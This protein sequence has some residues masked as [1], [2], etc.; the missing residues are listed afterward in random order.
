MNTY[1]IEHLRDQGKPFA[2]AMLLRA[3]HTGEPFVT[4]GA[5]KAELQYQLDI[6]SI[7]T[8]HIGSVAGGLMDDILGQDPKA[9]LLN[10]MV[11]RP[12]GIPSRGAANY[13]ADRYRRQR[14]RDWASIPKAEKIALVERERKKYLLTHTGRSLRTNYTGIRAQEN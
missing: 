2:M 14:L 9:P 6:E 5:I 11:A 8:I 13:L 3:L 4:Y 7:F 12:N 1:T 10:V